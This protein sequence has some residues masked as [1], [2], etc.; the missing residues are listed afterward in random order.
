MVKIDISGDIITQVNRVKCE[1]NYGIQSLI[2]KGI[3][4][5][6]VSK[7]VGK[8]SAGLPSGLS[9]KFQMV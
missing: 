9:E 4:A 1:I 8:H 3:V 7:L 5:I 2:P 6:D